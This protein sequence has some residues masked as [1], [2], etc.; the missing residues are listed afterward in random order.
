MY[1]HA[2]TQN[3]VYMRIQLWREERTY[4]Q[5]TQNIVYMRIQLYNTHSAFHYDLPGYSKSECTVALEHC[6][7]AHT[8]IQHTQCLSL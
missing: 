4:M 3:I 5:V 2:G 1:I 6:I 7:Y 8:T